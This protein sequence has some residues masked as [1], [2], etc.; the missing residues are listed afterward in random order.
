MPAVKLLNIFAL[1]TL[2][3]LLCSFAPSHTLALSIQANHL[4]RQSPNHHHGIAKKKKRDTQRCKPKPSTSSPPVPAS[5]P[6][7]SPAPS[8]SSTPGSPANFN[9][10]DVTPTS[11]TPNSVQTN[12]P[13]TSS[14]TGKLAIAWAMDSDPRASILL[15]SSRVIMWHVWSADIPDILKNANAVVSIMLWGPGYVDDFVAK[16]QAGYATHAFGP[17]EYVE[18]T[19]VYPQLELTRSLQGQRTTPGQYRSWHGC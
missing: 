5:S 11:T 13:A 19:W 8:L 1:S 2:A 3:V 10:G 14:G 6:Y 18:S 12:P 16:A 9:A 17:N 15:A 7:D 4:A